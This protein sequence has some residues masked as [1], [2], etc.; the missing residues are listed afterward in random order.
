MK[1][2]VDALKKCNRITMLMEKK[3]TFPTFDAE[4]RKM[5]SLNKRNAIIFKLN[6]LK[7]CHGNG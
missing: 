7:H 3:E 1:L 4:N 5:F 6:C 2:L